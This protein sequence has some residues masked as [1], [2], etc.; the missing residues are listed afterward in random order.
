MSDPPRRYGLVPAVMLA[1][2]AVLGGAVACAP[3]SAGA[4]AL[5]GYRID[6]VITHE[7]G[8]QS[9]AVLFTGPTRESRETCAS[10][11]NATVQLNGAPI[12]PVND[13][14]WHPLLLKLMGATECDDPAVVVDIPEGTS[15]AALL[16]IDEGAEHFALAFD[17]GFERVDME[18]VSLDATSAQV[19]LSAP[20]AG[21]VKAWLRDDVTAPAT[22][23]TAAL[24]GDVIRVTLP[25]GY[26]EH[27]LHVRLDA[28]VAVTTCEGFALCDDALRG[29]HGEL[30]VTPW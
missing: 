23:A 29:A 5:T 1:V 7:A 4:G 22:D 24:E 12:T 3:A 14:G 2:V 10:L 26:E 25:P 16:E 15:G 20:Y 9:L 11:E 28:H 27:T 8:E 13:G 17:E 21:D 30:D 19:R 18:L 6:P